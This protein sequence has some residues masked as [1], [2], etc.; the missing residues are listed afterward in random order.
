MGKNEGSPTDSAVDVN[1][2]PVVDLQDTVLPSLT[3]RRVG[4]KQFKIIY[5][6]ERVREHLC[7][8]TTDALPP[9]CIPTL[10]PLISCA[11]PSTERW[12]DTQEDLHLRRMSSSFGRQL[13][14]GEFPSHFLKPIPAR[15]PFAP[16]ARSQ[17]DDLERS[18]RN[19][20]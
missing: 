13:A 18:I 1:D 4:R 11:G 10:L 5:G 9:A 8:R 2:P 6:R 7:P 3:S 15:D 20:C 14:L 12:G 16:P 19:I 17:T